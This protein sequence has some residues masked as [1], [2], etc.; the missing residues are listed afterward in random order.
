MTAH[1]V[2]TCEV[3]FVAQ[4]VSQQQS[5]TAHGAQHGEETFANLRRCHVTVTEPSDL[6]VQENLMAYRKLADMPWLGRAL[7]GR[8]EPF[9]TPFAGG[10]A[11]GIEGREALRRWRVF[12]GNFVLTEVC[13]NCC[14]GTRRSLQTTNLHVEHTGT[15]EQ[16]TSR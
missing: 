6:L 9:E 11:G 10:V 14:K 16:N 4:R 15:G 7:G 13:V 12:I 1:L 2:R 3:V 5:A 8:G